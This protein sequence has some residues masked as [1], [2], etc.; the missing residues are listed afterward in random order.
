[1]R[2]GGT[3][4]VQSSAPERGVAESPGTASFWDAS[5]DGSKVF[6]TTTEGLV[7]G[8]DDGATDVYEYDASKPASDLHNL[9]RLSVDNEPTDGVGA[10]ATGVIGASRD[11][12][13]VY[14]LALNQL[15]AGASVVNGSVGL[16]VAHAGLV[17]FIGSVPLADE[18]DM[19]GGVTVGLSPLTSRVS[20]DGSR[21]A[22]TASSGAGLTG[23]PHAATC[24]D[25]ANSACRE[26]YVYYAQANGGAGELVCASCAPDG[27]LP[28]AG[29]SIFEQVGQGATGTGR[30]EPRALTSDAKRLFFMSRKRLLPADHNGIVQDIYERNLDTRT[31]S[32]VTS[33]EGSDDAFF[34]DASSSGDDV[35]FVTRERLVESDVDSAY[36]LYDARVGGDPGLGEVPFVPAECMGADS[37]RGPLPIAPSGMPPSTDSYRGSGNS[38]EH[39]RV[40][41]VKKARRAKRCQKA[42]ARKA[43]K[44]GEVRLHVKQARLAR[45]AKR[46]IKHGKASAG[47]G[48]SR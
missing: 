43:N 41:P 26:I 12:A 48:V 33:G 22:F 24:E 13:Y 45:G 39:T 31:L 32:L 17:R 7:E 27:S 9:S 23:Y 4:T 2:V 11:G 14:F 1:M 35:F 25:L 36:D 18:N 10:G 28:S 6:F 38:A 47:R 30:L 40:R 46:C 34:L 42:H 21:L 29:S 8:D 15:V 19:L 5:A 37:C 3:S 20:V 16:F 44:A